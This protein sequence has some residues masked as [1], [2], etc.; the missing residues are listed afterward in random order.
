MN[1]NKPIIVVGSINIDF[2]MSAPRIPLAGETIQGNG[3]EQHFGGKGANQAVAVAR[4]GYPVEMIGRVGSDV[5]GE[6]MRASLRNEGVGIEAVELA[7]GPSG[8]ASITVSQSGQNAIVVTS[9]ANA[10]LTPEYLDQHQERIRNAGMVLTQLEVPLRTVEHLAELC[11]RYQV[12]LILDPA[13]AQS[14]PR[15]LLSHVA[16]FTPNETEAAF[17]AESIDPALRDASPHR[18]AAAFMDLGMGA[19]ALKLGERGAFIASSTTADELPA[20]P[21]E[22]VDSTAAGDTFNG[23]FAVGLISGMHPG[24]AAHFA[25][26]AA[27]IA[28]TRC[29]AQPSMPNRSEVDQLLNEARD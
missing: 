12:P 29:G 23:A 4:L 21:V 7:P 6:Q 22:V 2:V 10:H 11:R 27:A 28:V 24:E 5:F 18:L 25:C 14:L 8:I 20:I 19:V 26:A 1:K 17:Y 3:F 16:W 9:G 13:P 15:T